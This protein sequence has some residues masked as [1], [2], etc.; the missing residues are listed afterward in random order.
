M[1]IDPKVKAVCFD[2]DGTLVDDRYPSAQIHERFLGGNYILH[3]L[4]DMIQTSG[5]Q[6]AHNALLAY[7]E[8]NVYWDYSDIIDHFNLDSFL[9]TEWI[10]LWHKNHLVALWRN[11][12]LIH[13]LRNKGYKIYII[14]NNPHTGCLFK[15]EHTGLVDLDGNGVIDEIFGSNRGLGQKWDIGFWKRVIEQ[16][17]YPAEAMAMIGDNPVED[18]EVPLAAGFCQ[19]FLVDSEGKL[20]EAPQINV[21]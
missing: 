16:S 10:R 9:V 17:P 4:G 15:L 12:Q 11:V 2:I 19:S 14:S 7:T 6:D 8:V 21:V 5:H 1:E 20:Q 18:A 3:L 13:K